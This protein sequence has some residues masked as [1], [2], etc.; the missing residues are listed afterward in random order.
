M[1]K[2]LEL[3][4]NK[5]QSNLIKKYKKNKYSSILIWFIEIK[6]ND[7]LRVMLASHIKSSRVP[8]Q[9]L[10]DLLKDKLIRET[11]IIGDYAITSQGVWE[12][13][14]NN[15]IISNDMLLENIDDKYFN[16]YKEIGKPLSAKE[17]V[18]IFSM[19]SARAFSKKSPVYLKSEKNLLD[20]WESIINDSY[21]ILL[22]LSFVKVLTE[23]ELFGKP[24]NEHKVSALFRHT[25][26]L[27]KKTRGIYMCANSRDQKYYLDIYKEGELC[28]DSLKF[29]FRQVFSGKNLI[30]AEVDSICNFCDKT[31]SSK[32]IYIFNIREHL[33]HKPEYD[34]AI[35][36]ALLTS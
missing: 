20:N 14:R 24:G 8:E 36:D 32:S 23:N 11:N 7:R 19:I 4:Y 33:F 18:I 10:R 12:Y 6:S 13:E 31:A 3:F 2:Y 16:T 17:K 30:A 34:T 29:I 22:S 15:G 1:I 26:K 9:S 21:S 25:D 5:L 28:Q 27:S 35:R